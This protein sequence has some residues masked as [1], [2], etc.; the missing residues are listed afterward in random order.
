MSNVSHLSRV[1]LSNV[2][3]SLD[4]EALADEFGRLVEVEAAG[5]ATP[6]EV[7]DLEALRKL[8]REVENVAGPQFRNAV[9]VPG[10]LFDQYAK[11][12]FRGLVDGEAVLMLPFVDWASLAR[13][14]CDANFAVV[15]VGDMTFCVEVS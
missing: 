12:H 9:V 1:Y 7:A 5:S 14:W 2:S 6:G 15:E 11:D 8:I 13:Q 3:Q 10:A 4:T